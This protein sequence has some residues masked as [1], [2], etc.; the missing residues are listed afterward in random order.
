MGAAA[1]EATILRLTSRLAGKRAAIVQAWSAWRREQPVATA[2]ALRQLWAAARYRA[3]AHRPA[4]PLLVLAGAGD[5]LVDPCCSRR[6]AALWQTAFA[7]HPAAGHDV[8]LDDGAW[9]ARQVRDWLR[10]A[11]P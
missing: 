5:E 11:A 4:V 2:N 9:V 7:E 3:P 1:R 8:P 6:L 10:A